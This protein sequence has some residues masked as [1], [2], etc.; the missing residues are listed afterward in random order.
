M[1]GKNLAG[2]REA[3]GGVGLSSHGYT[4]GRDGKKE[5]R[6]GAQLTERFASWSVATDGREQRCRGPWQR[7]WP[8]WTGRRRQAT[9]RRSYD[10]RRYRPGAGS[11]ALRS[12][13]PCCSSSS[14]WRRRWP[15]FGQG[16]TWSERLFHAPARMPPCSQRRGRRCSLPDINAN[17]IFSWRPKAYTVHDQH[18]AFCIGKMQFLGVSLTVRRRKA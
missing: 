7:R 14:W 1:E 17:A 13:R 9:K 11:G 5:G 3:A 10:R 16:G 12:R 15:R 18:N 6:G 2:P 8:S 4:L